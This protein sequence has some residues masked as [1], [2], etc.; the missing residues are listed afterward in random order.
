MSHVVVSNT[1]QRFAATTSLDSKLRSGRPRILSRRDKRYIVQSSKRH[2][3]LIRKQL[4][5][6]LDR[7]GSSS[8]VCRAL[9]EHKYRKWR[10]L[11]RIPLT[12]DV[13]RDRYAF[14]CY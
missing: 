13:A 4:L 7:K 14:A 8:T 5:K 1:I 3:R 2:T 11:K 10:A 12:V 9:R 6:V